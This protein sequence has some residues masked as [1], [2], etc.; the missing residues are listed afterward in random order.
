MVI[1]IYV[2]AV[3]LSNGNSVVDFAFKNNK[4]PKNNSNF[5]KSG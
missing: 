2:F 1:V 3:S 4:I 5:S